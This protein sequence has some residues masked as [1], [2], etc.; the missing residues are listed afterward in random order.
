MIQVALTYT[1]TGVLT[2]IKSQGHAPKPWWAG[3]FGFSPVNQLCTALSA[4][5]YNLLYSLKSLSKAELKTEVR[6]GHF[7]LVVLS[8]PEGEEERVNALMASYAVGV[9]M[10]AGQFQGKI[11]IIQ[12][13]KN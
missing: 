3:L 8:R 10:L 2:A 4:I 9:H 11:K 12:E 13:S 6:K 1:P 7:Q 5:E